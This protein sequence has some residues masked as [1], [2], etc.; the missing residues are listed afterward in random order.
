MN[1]TDEVRI[2]ACDGVLTVTLNRPQAK[3]AANRAMAVAVAAAMDQ[4]DQREDLRVGI[5]TGAGGTFCAGMDLKAFLSG[6]LP[7][8]EGR[9]FCGL[10]EAPPRK[11]L[12]A[13]VEGYALAGGCELA[14]AC[15]LIVAGKGAQFGLS[16][17]KRGLVARGGGLL[18]LP[19][20][21][22]YRV[23]MEL[24]LTGD[25]LGAED[26]LRFG[27]INRVV[28]AGHALEEARALAERVSANGP[29]AVVASKRVLRDSRGWSEEEMFQ[30]Q[31]EITT[32]VF[33]SED[34]KEG[35]RAFAE[36]RPAMWRGV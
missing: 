23:A 25:P 30:R 35:A 3:N 29:L 20:Q 7:R 12:I 27:L 18:R 2:E 15:D 11:P 31:A 13:A 5:L 6:E 21:L 19:R 36:K 24:V 8:V 26:A 34:A 33:A 22:P 9:G 1:M 10:T 28:S 16:E 32:P 4:L 14:L 17:V